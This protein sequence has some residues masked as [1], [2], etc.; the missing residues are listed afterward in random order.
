MCSARSRCAHYLLYQWPFWAGL[1]WSTLQQAGEIP[2]PPQ[3]LKATGPQGY[4]ATASKYSCWGHLF[5][6]PSRHRKLPW[7]VICMPCCASPGKSKGGLFSTDLLRGIGGAQIWRQPAK[8]AMGNRQAAPSWAR[9]YLESP[10]P[11]RRPGPHT[12]THAQH[13][14]RLAAA[15]PPE[16][17][18]AVAPINNGGGSGLSE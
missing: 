4:S 12:H 18:A 10:N 11:H 6:A 1:Y 15:V 16:S 14:C 5:P 8:L 7:G 17:A 2:P 3:G 9:K 13:N